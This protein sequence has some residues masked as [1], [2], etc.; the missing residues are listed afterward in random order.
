MSIQNLLTDQAAQIIGAAI[1][2]AGLAWGGMTVTVSHKADRED[3]VRLEAKVD[4]LIRG[5]DRIEKTLVRVDEK[6]DRKADKP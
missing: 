6:L 3:V 1:L 2:G 4:A 5:N